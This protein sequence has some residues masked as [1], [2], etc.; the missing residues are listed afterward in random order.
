[1]SWNR[2]KLIKLR[3]NIRLA[4]ASLSDEAALATP[5]LFPAWQADADYGKGDRVRY[6]GQLYRLIPET[7]HSQADWPPDLIPAIWARVADPAEEWPEWVQ[8]LGAEDAYPAGAKV[9]YQ[10]K[11]WIN[12]YGDGNVWAPGVFGWEEAD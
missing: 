9:S 1:M 12:T 11:R 3:Q 5:E 6:G 10:G 2:E 8:P 4:A 7:H